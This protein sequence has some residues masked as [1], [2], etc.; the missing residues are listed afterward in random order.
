MCFQV[1]TA[2][3][4]FLAVLTLSAAPMLN[5]EYQFKQPDGTMVPVVV[6]GDEYYQHVES[7]AGYTL[8]RGANGWIRYADISADGTRLIPQ[9]IY[10]KNRS[11]RPGGATR[12]TL[13][14]AAVQ[15]IA[16]STRRLLDRSAPPA[17]RS[18]SPAP[19]T[20]SVRGLTIIIDFSDEPA[21]ISENEFDD[22]INGTDYTGYSNE[23]S[24]REWFADV[25]RGQLDYQ[26]EIYGYYRAQNTFA[27]YD[28]PNASFGTRARE[29]I[30]EALAHM[31]A[32][33]YDFSALDEVNGSVPLNIYYAGSPQNGW[34]K[35]LWP[36]KSGFSSINYGSKTF[37][38]YQISDI[39]GELSMGTFVHENGHMLLSY[40]DLYPYDDGVPDQ[41]IRQYCTMGYGATSYSKNPNPYNPVF[42]ERSGWL[43]PVD[44]AGISDTTITQTPD[45]IGA[46]T[47]YTNGSNEGFYIDGRTKTGRSAEFP[48]SGVIIWHAR[49][50]GSNTSTA[51]YPL[52]RVVEAD[53]NGTVYQSSDFFT[54]TT[55]AVFTVTTSPAADWHSGAASGLELNNLS[56]SSTQVTYD[57]GT[58][59]SGVTYTLTVTEGTG[60]GDY[61]AGT[62]VDVS[63]DTP[64]EGMIFD[65]WTGDTAHL[66]DPAAADAVFTMPESDAAI[67]ATYEDT[68]T[69]LFTLTVNKGTGGGDYAAGDSVDITAASAAPDSAFAYWSGATGYLEDS[70]TAQARLAMPADDL[71]LSATYVFDLDT[72]GLGENLIT[73]AGWEG[74]ADSYGSVADV[75]TSLVGE[76][77]RILADLSLVEDDVAAEEYSWAK[78]S[79]YFDSA[80]TEVDLIALTYTADQE[81]RFVL[82]D[83]AL[84][85]QGVAYGAVL[86]AAADTTVYLPLEAFN[87]PTDWDVPDSLQAPLSMEKISAVSLAARNKSAT[88]AIILTSMR[89][90][91]YDPGLTGLITEGRI[92]PDRLSA[93]LVGN[94]LRLG[95]PRGDTYGITVMTPAGRTL[96]AQTSPLTAG[97]HTLEFPGLSAGIY[98]L[99]ITSPAEH[100]VLRI[101]TQ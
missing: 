39:G 16:D 44:L 90:T 74:L 86:P 37:S 52:L 99:R 66:N 72:T 14:A 82:E 24:I 19:V 76:E 64:A 54:S 35:G 51:S 17:S 87:H 36:H 43:T 10:R 42:R 6:S 9:D 23:G 96:Y 67:T 101:Q 80:F 57:I 92:T 15:R 70:T 68:T 49:E 98:L 26:T 93:A 27:Y 65:G 94:T 30:Q 29:L 7:P 48:A 77:G 71:T 45:G 75:D 41:W 95:I 79:A 47:K 13:S 100:R 53:A 55:G 1:K 91:N 73:Y 11:S 59:S 8:T 84:S 97:M 2:L 56:F 69:E 58:G 78:G 12:K 32:Q 22:F 83:T 50:D 21:T 61:T 46:V 4:L 5:K 89:F 85:S 88:T 20:G 38:Q 31:D 25:S 18:I 34:S 3:V 28:D 62:A 33:G 63:A 60:D 81:F 40:P